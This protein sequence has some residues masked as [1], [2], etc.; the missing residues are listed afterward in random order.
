MRTITEFS[1]LF[2]IENDPKG[3]NNDCTDFPKRPCKF[4]GRTDRPQWK[5]VCNIDCD[6]TGEL[7]KLR[8]EV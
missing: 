5:G 1:H 4:C 8:G 2:G 3:E 7:S 6:P